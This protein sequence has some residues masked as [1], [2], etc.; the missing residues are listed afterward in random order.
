M[1]KSINLE[2]HYLINLIKYCKSSLKTGQVKVK[3]GMKSLYQ[4]IKNKTKLYKVLRILKKFCKHLKKFKRPSMKKLC[5]KRSQHKM[6]RMMRK[7]IVLL[8]NVY[9]NL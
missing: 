5:L 8:F 4:R 9:L 3:N 2:V 1:K 7:K 6:K